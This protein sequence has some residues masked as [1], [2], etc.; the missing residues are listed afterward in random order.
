[1]L[2]EDY[3]F[4]PD[5]FQSIVAAAVEGALAATAS[6]RAALKCTLHETRRFEVLGGVQLSVADLL[7]LVIY[8]G[9]EELPAVISENIIVEVASGASLY[10]FLVAMDIRRP[11]RLP[12]LRQSGE[13]PSKRE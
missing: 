9:K 12:T 6:L 11:A 4:I 13:C 2:V 10:S 3:Q 5:Q 1:L 8:R 7:F